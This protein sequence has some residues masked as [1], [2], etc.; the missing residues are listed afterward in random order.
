MNKYEILDSVG[1]GAYGIVLKCRNRETDE[2]V[3]VKK[4]K[5]TEDDEAVRKTTMR[6][7]R[8]LQMLRNHTGIVNLKEAFRR[9]GRLYLVFEYVG[10]NLLETLEEAP[11]GLP[12]DLARR[13]AYMLT[14]AIRS[15][16]AAG[17]LHRD[18]KPENLLI[19]ARDASLKLC[20]FGFARQAD[21]ENGK[22]DVKYTDYVA[23]R[24]YRSPELLLGS[25]HYTEK[26]DTWAVGC[27]TSEMFTGQP[28]FPGDSE[29]DQVFLIQR[30]LGNLGEAQ[31]QLFSANPRYSHYVLPKVARPDTLDRRLRGTAG[32][33]AVH[34]IKCMLHL[35]PRTRLS[36][37]DALRH[38]WFDGQKEALRREVNL[39]FFPLAAPFKGP[40]AGLRSVSG[41]SGR[42]FDRDAQRA[43]AAFSSHRPQRPPL[44]KLSLNESCQPVRRATAEAP[45]GDTTS[46]SLHNACQPTGQ[47]EPALAEKRKQL[48]GAGATGAV[49]RPH[50]ACH[51]LRAVELSE[52]ATVSMSDR[53]LSSSG[54][55]WLSVDN[56]GQRTVLDPSTEN[57]D[58][59]PSEPCLSTA[60]TRPSSLD[61]TTAE[62]RMA[63]SGGSCPLPNAAPPPPSCLDEPGFAGGCLSRSV[64]ARPGIGAIGDLALQ[65][66]LRG[67]KAK[68]KG[69][70]SKM[71]SSSHPPPAA[72]LSPC[73]SE[74]SGKMTPPALTCLP[75]EGP[76]SRS[77][78]DGLV[79]PE[80][81]GLRFDR[82]GGDAALTMVHAPS[83]DAEGTVWR[84]QR[85]HSRRRSA[86]PD[87]DAVAPSRGSAEEP[88]SKPAVSTDMLQ[89]GAPPGNRTGRD[90][91][92][93]EGSLQPSVVLSR[94]GLLPLHT[95]DDELTHN[96][97][98]WSN[99]GPKS[100]DKPEPLEAEVDL[101]SLCAPT[102]E[103]ASKGGEA[104]GPGAA[105]K[106]QR[107][108]HHQHHHHA[109]HR[110]S[111]GG[112]DALPPTLAERA[113]ASHLP[114]QLAAPHGQPPDRTAA[115]ALPQ[116]RPPDGHSMPLALRPPAAVCRLLLGFF[117]RV[118]LF[119][120]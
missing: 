41:A 14:R 75:S 24:W 39:T 17:I 102:A 57:R 1:E 78:Q 49:A 45:K 66:F 74:A 32:R 82:L 68:A 63:H 107:H 11:G 30:T 91:S 25:S 114:P 9:K 81:G 8:V 92:A 72:V 51:P 116:R 55:P 60:N 47:G 18:I 5:E 12:S 29:A 76:A 62:Q 88:R 42:R 3:A 58:P 38:A 100:C 111:A 16:H 22:C 65:P 93:N 28:L 112:K 117:R 59:P 64:T 70:E 36:S 94:N 104:A 120:H 52:D 83:F 109:P 10:K 2:I 31:A 105:A 69:C 71:R 6:E 110:A 61:A 101:L 85:R 106:V 50:E 21:A 73:R 84:D 46:H 4:F 43:A 77:S 79:A 44:T 23:T 96:L 26:V 34:F 15:C 20:D 33:A 7:V 27:I 113:V 19:N 87:A 119:T 80:G 35:D 40:H 115:V 118:G 53:K 37:A 67:G 97:R 108:R 13:Y 90:G 89:S 54:R 48:S 56:S 98:D 103:R 86:K 99:T 95:S